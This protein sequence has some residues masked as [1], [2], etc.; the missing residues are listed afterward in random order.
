MFRKLTPL[1]LVVLTLGAALAIGATHSQAAEV[2][3]RLVWKYDGGFFKD[4]G[5]NQW[6]EKNP[7]GTYHFVEACRNRDYI[8]L[9]DRSRDVTVRLYRRECFLKGL[10]HRDFVKLYCGRWSE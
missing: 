1:I 9:F 8:D 2:P 10:G 4:Q 3:H 5:S 7:S 6:I